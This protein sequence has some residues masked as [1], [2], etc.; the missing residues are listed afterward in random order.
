[1]QQEYVPSDDATSFRWL[2]MKDN[3]CIQVFA[4]RKDNIRITSGQIVAL[5]QNLASC[6]IPLEVTSG[7]QSC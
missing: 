7:M 6:Q 4:S 2:H 3:L 5:S 1:M